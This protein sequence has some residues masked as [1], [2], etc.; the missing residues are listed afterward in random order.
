[1]VIS[2]WETLNMNCCSE[3]SDDWKEE[4][5]KLISLV[6]V[7]NHINFKVR[8]SVSKMSKRKCNDL[9]LADRY[10]VVKL[11]DQKLTQ[12]EISKRLGSS[13][14]SLWNL[15]QYHSIV[16]WAIQAQ[17]AEPLVYY[18]SYIAASNT[19]T[20]GQTRTAACTLSWELLNLLH[21]LVIH[22]D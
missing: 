8:H 12:T 9:T 22:G 4:V 17:W 16:R 10:E 14:S 15:L 1:M 18:F 13:I 2:I 3:V 21:W 11:L 6:L 7:K 19:S 20:R 5:S